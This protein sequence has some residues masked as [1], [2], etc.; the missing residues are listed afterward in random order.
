MASS[1]AHPLPH[2]LP[3]RKYLELKAYECLEG[4][5]KASSLPAHNELV[6]DRDSLLH[7]PS[8]NFRS[9]LTVSGEPQ[10]LQQARL[11]RD[12][13]RLSSSISRSPFISHKKSVWE[14]ELQ[15][16][17]LGSPVE[18]DGRVCASF[19]PVAVTS[20]AGTATGEDASPLSETTPVLPLNPD[21]F[22]F[23][24]WRCLRQWDEEDIQTLS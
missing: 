3:A 14:S 7:I 21:L 5:Q 8:L 23:R 2:I 19:F 18:D 4:S 20:E 11:E 22:L 6:Q 13:S 17:W 15:A 16:P 9:S 10:T 12:A 1:P 24:L